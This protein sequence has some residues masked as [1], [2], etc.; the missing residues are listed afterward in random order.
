MVDECGSDQ[1]LVLPAR[2]GAMREDFAPLWDRAEL[3]GIEDL[4]RSRFPCQTS[5]LWQSRGCF[6][7]ISSGVLWAVYG[8]GEEAVG[9]A[10]LG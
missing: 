4:S 3:A 2:R 6:L 10:E 9:R 5:R 8:A 1:A 7:G